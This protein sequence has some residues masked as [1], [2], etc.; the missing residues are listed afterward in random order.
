MNRPPER[1]DEAARLEALRQYAL[2]ET[3][4]EQALDDLAALAAQICGTPFGLISLADEHRQWFKARVGIEV[5]ETPR[6]NFFCGHAIQQRD[7]FAVMDAAQ[8]ERF[9]RHPLVAGEPRL[10]FYAG[11]PL[12][13]EAGHALG[14][15]CVLDRVP[16]TLTD[17]QEHALRTLARQVTA[18]LELRRHTRELAVRERLLQVVFDSEPECVKLLGP[19]GSLR[20]MNRAGL[21]MIEAE[22]FESVANQCVYP[23]IVPEHRAAFRDLTERVFRGESGQLQF[24]IAGLKGTRRWLE[25]HATPLRGESG[26]VTALL[27]VTR[28]IT[29]RKAAEEELRRARRRSELLARLGVQ[30]AEARTVKSA[31]RLVLE[32]ARE[33]LGWDC[34][35]LELW[36]ADKERF[37]PVLNYD[38]VDGRVTEF[39]PNSGLLEPTPMARRVLA[40]GATLLLRQCDDEHLELLQPY[41]SGRRSRSLLFVPIRHQAR[42]VGLA[43]IQSYDLNAYDHAALAVFQSLVDQWSGALER[44]RAEEALRESEANLAAS[45]AQARLGSWSRDVAT[46]RGVWSREM[47]RLFGCDPARGAPP[48]AEFLTRL[49]P[50]DRPTVVTALERVAREGGSLLVEFRSDPARGPLRWFEG[51]ASARTDESGRVL[52]LIGTTQDITERK[53]AEEAVKILSQAIEQTNDSV[54]ITNRDGVIQYVN[55]GFERITGYTATETIGHTPRLLRSGCHPETFYRELW[56]TVLAGRTFHAEFINRRQSG[57]IY[58]EDKVISPL[59]N[60]KGDITHFVSVGRDTTERRRTQEEQ[61]QLEEQLRQ[62]QKMDAIGQLAGGVAHDFNN[63][64]AVMIMQTDLMAIEDAAPEEVQ[65]GIRQIRAA[66][67]RAANLTRQLLLFSRRQVL[68][69]RDLDLNDVVTSLARML[70]R[71]IGEDVQLQLHLHAGPLH[72]R[73]D[74]GMLDQILL[75]LAVN[76]RDAMPQGGR[77]LIETN[78]KTVGADDLEPGDDAAPGRYVSLSVSDT[79]CGIPAEV[80]AHIFEPFFTT[81]EPGKGTGL[82]LATVFGIV[83]QHQ[84]WLKVESEPGHGATFRIFFPALAQPALAPAE[85]AKPAVRGGS[86][87][88]LLVEDDA[89]VR[90]LSRAILARHGYH[91]LEAPDGVSALRLWAEHRHEVALLITDLVMP[92]GF[93]GH[94]LAARLQQDKPGLKIIFVSGYS[95]DIA[96]RELE[97]HAGENFLQKPFL[98]EHLLETIRRSLDA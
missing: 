27:S 86:E 74:A 48:F 91:V 29:A 92:G 80:A 95:A 56:E 28:D 23:L 77:L 63:I 35:W 83:K 94:E 4:P 75:N 97:L 93:N 44:I 7:V 39:M 13:T 46:G 3:A 8:D 72:T 76:A 38:V 81:K 79:G 96:G 68:Q 25:T 60:E 1:V 32:A 70:Q 31:A 98:P 88:I 61:R 66:A 33:W 22:S 6:E 65:E 64:L 17:F 9:A 67:E 89:N 73:A 20:L 51:R 11:V 12:C 85:V 84:G 50:E 47:F 52:A 87:T 45:Q 54:V 57:E 43:S 58:H 15:L 78:E 18:Q 71:I 53:H 26:Q 62:S 2:L 19:D 55:A 40:E 37:E 42:L 16:R 36:H 59:R 69:P 41:G 5:T 24:E 34:A 49:H 21:A 30:L 82:G 10:R 14:T 90:A